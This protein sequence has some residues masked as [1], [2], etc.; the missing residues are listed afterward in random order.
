MKIPSHVFWSKIAS[1]YLDL[2]DISVFEASIT[3]HGVR[4]S[5]QLYPIQLDKNMTPRLPTDGFLS[6]N[7]HSLCANEYTNVYCRGGTVAAT[8]SSHDSGSNETDT[9][10]ESPV[11]AS[12]LKDLSLSRFTPSSS[13]TKASNRGHLPYLAIDDH[14]QVD[15]TSLEMLKWCERRSIILRNVKLSFDPTRQL[16]A[17]VKSS[18]RLADHG[19]DVMNHI[20][21]LTVNSSINYKLLAPRML[22]LKSI[23]FMEYNISL[24]FEDFFSI[25][26]LFKSNMTRPCYISPGPSA[27][28]EISL[29]MEEFSSTLALEYLITG[30]PT[31]KSF[32]LQDDY[33]VL[34]DYH[35]YLMASYWHN[36]NVLHLHDCS[37]N[38]TGLEE[39][40]RTGQ[41]FRSIKLERCHNITIKGLS[42]LLNQSTATLQ[43]LILGVKTINENDIVSMLEKFTELRH[44]EFVGNY[45]HHSDRIVEA[46]VRHCQNIKVLILL[47]TSITDYGVSILSTCK[48]IESLKLGYCPLV[49][50]PEIILTAPDRKKSLV[51]RVDL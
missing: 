42:S 51:V 37:V 4:A 25:L 11:Y 48:T 8:S 46:V 30:V 38:D 49:S 39:F 34:S 29:V 22:S 10:C 24:T 40:S 31:I 33:R 12:I 3:N 9:D 13:S 7:F 21:S 15:I 27:L 17:Y 26:D 50:R 19:W 16:T 32:K 6:K 1:P 20:T 44:L 18:E 47:G 41:C 28:E 35:V 45:M 23:S 2:K 43:Q 5:L 14:I 36:L